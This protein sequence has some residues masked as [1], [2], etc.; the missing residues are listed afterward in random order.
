MGHNV[1]AN[2]E[3]FPPNV[4]FRKS[5]MFPRRRDHRDGE[6]FPRG[7][8]DGETFPGRV[9]PKKTFVATG[10][11]SVLPARRGN[12][13]WT[14]LGTESLGGGGGGQQRTQR[15]TERFQQRG[16]ILPAS[17]MFPRRPDFQNVSPVKGCIMFPRRPV[18]SSWGHSYEIRP[19]GEH[20]RRVPLPVRRGNIPGRFSTNVSPLPW[21]SARGRECFPVGRMAKECFPV[22]AVAEC[23][24]VAAVPATGKHYGNV[25][26]L[27]R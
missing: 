15:G 4:H 18:S 26:P 20:F 10:K 23:F 24:P 3:T 1:R 21:L 7:G 2:G 6:T 27:G 5:R 9:A 17:N 14:L 22:A 25:S 12:I 8:A 11:H 13:S 19:T 16:N